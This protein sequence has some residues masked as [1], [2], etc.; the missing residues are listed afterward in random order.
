MK[1]ICKIFLR[2]GII[3]RAESNESSSTMIGYSDVT[4]TVPNHLLI[5]WSKNLLA[6]SHATVP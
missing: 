2:M 3:F 5:M 4:V 6:T 1:F